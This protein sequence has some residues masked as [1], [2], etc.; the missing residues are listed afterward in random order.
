MNTNRLTKAIGQAQFP[1][2]RVYHIPQRMDNI[3]PNIGI[4][5]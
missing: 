3:R 2:R 5:N 4:M 1:K